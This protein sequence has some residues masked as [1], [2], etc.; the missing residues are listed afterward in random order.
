MLEKEKAELLLNDDLE[1]L[2]QEH[3]D[4]IRQLSEEKEE[5]NTKMNQYLNENMELLD[6]LEKISKGSSAESIEMVANLTVEEKLEI[7][8]YQQGIV[9]HHKDEEIPAEISHELNES[10]RSLRLESSELMEKI[11]L[12]TVE[13]REVLEKLENLTLENQVLSGNLESVKDEKSSLENEVEKLK[14]QIDDFEKC[15]SDIKSEKEE[16]SERM[17]ELTDHRTKLQEEINKLV[18]AELSAA[19]SLPS[20][21][22]KAHKSDNSEPEAL[23][24]PSSPTSIDRDACEKLLKQLESEIQNLNKNK[25]KNQKLK[26]SKKL[27]DNAKNVHAMMTNL[28]IEFYKNLD[29][30]KQ[31]REDLE[32]VKILLNNVSS[33]K[34]NEEL[35]NLETKLNDSIEKLSKKS[36]ECEELE[37]KLSDVQSSNVECFDAQIQ[38]LKSQ[39]ELL[40]EESNEKDDLIKKMQENV[41]SLISERDFCEKEVEKQ[42]TLVSDLRLEFDQLCGDVK[43]NNKR[44]NEKS[45]E[46]DQLQHEFDMRLKTSTSEVEVLK[47]LVAEQKQLLIDA[48][49]EHELDINQ[50]IK[51]IEDCQHEI[52]KLNDELEALRSQNATNQEAYAVDLRTEMNKMKELLAESNREIENQKEELLHKQETIDTLNTQIIDLYKSMEENSNKLIEKED[53]IQYIQE[54]SDGNKEEIRKAFDRISS[55]DKTINDL[56]NQLSK[57]IHETEL[58]QQKAPAHD[59]KLEERIKQLENE[60]HSLE[61]KS[62]EQLDKLKKYAANLKKKQAQCAELEEKLSSQTSKDVD[63]LNELRAKVIHYEEQLNNVKIENSKLTQESVQ[64]SSVADEIEDLRWKIDEYE[65]MIEDKSKKIAELEKQLSVMSSQC[66]QVEENSFELQSQLQKSENEKCKLE[67]KIKLTENLEK[68]LVTIKEEL[69]ASKMHEGEKS[70]DKKKVSNFNFVITSWFFSEIAKS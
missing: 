39:I 53:E 58:L 8:E 57:K 16:M 7:E 27:S 62:K 65:G 19:S 69:A 41:E 15:L 46:L 21:P 1:K 30:C 31:L 48:Y 5:I 37:N 59:P 55:A 14:S 43:I 25:D 11:E 9:L 50:K 56:K 45:S 47:T 10:L 60:N 3:E 34:N 70:E 6:K 26:I 51:E 63:S 54:I 36:S 49:Q 32:K 24:E 44:L 67:E 29:D 2:N 13:R 20:S 40:T 33:D 42:K 28:L 68:E 17:A 64:K 4:R 12:F 52:K 38:E 22:L 66:D 61:A 23:S 18:R 35:K